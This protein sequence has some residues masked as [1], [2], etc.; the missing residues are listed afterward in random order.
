M[1]LYNIS[2]DNVRTFN[3]EP[4]VTAR[5]TQFN[6]PAG[7]ISADLEMTVQSMTMTH[8]IIVQ[9]ASK[10]ANETLTESVATECKFYT[11]IESMLW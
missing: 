3:S 4:W 2:S 10:V 9:C 7:F 6:R 11:N 5:W 8:Q 1:V